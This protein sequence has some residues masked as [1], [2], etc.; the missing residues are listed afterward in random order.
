MVALRLTLAILLLC[1][2]VLIPFLIWGEAMEHWIV[3]R[4]NASLAKPA[5]AA[6]IVGLLSAD[7]VLPLPSS[8]VAVWGGAKLGIFWGATAIFV[9]LMIGNLIGFWTGRRFGVPVVK[10]VMGGQAQ[11]PDRIGVAMLC[12]T[13]PVPVLSESATVIAGAGDMSFKQFL[14]A[15]GLSNAGIAIV[16]GVLGALATDVGSFLFVFA[17][18]IAVPAIGYLVYLAGM[19]F[20]SAE[21]N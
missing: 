2:L 21:P 1:V 19:S 15:A 6:L 8:L 16:Y 12:L 14:F 9:G 5:I 4:T 18:A 17:A 3:A 20:L 11:L 10:R 13:R 7:V